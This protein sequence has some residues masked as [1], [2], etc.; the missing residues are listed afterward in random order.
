MTSK[1][2]IVPVIALLL[3]GCDLKNDKKDNGPTRAALDHKAWRAS[4]TDSVDSL[5][6]L[7]DIDALRIDTLHMAIEKTATKFVEV[8]DPMLVEKYKVLNGWQ[9]Y[10]T[11][12]GTGVLARLLEDDTIELVVTST[13]G[14]FSSI[15]LSSEG[16][17]VSAGPVERGGALNATVGNVNRV[18]FNNAESVAEFVWNH[19]GRPV[20]MRF[21]N[22]ASIAL[23][24]NQ[25]NMIGQT[26]Y[27]LNLQK[28]LNEL[29]RHQVVIYNKIE[30]FKSEVAKDSVSYRDNR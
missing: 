6:N 21:S 17:S 1:I 25:K 15:T 9:G 27:L 24:E 2:L 3:C 29:E 16:E 20:T 22:G 19:Q 23:S 12:S 4:L 18:A 10:D 14:K 13:A 26:W 7:Y 30:L 28:E 11:T 8:S 5:H